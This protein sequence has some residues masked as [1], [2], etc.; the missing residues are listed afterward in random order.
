MR[1]IFSEKRTETVASRA[2]TVTGET[3]MNDKMIE[4]AIV[5]GVIARG[6]AHVWFYKGESQD[7]QYSIA[8]A[9]TNEWR[10]F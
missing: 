3:N 8:N 7:G 6:E 10:W 9:V 1:N 2:E 5:L 4:L